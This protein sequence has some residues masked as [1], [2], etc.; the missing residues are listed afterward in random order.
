MRTFIAM[1]ATAADTPGNQ[2]SKCAVDNLNA[3]AKAGALTERPNDFEGERQLVRYVFALNIITGKLADH[4]S[5]IDQNVVIWLQRVT[6]EST[7]SFGRRLPQ[8]KK[9]DNLYVWSGAAAAAYLLLVRD[10]AIDR[11]QRNVWRE[12]IDAIEPDGRIAL[13]LARKEHALNYHTYYLSALLWLRELRRALGMEPTEQDA[14]AISRLENRIR[15]VFCSNDRMIEG[16]PMRQNPPNR[17]SS[18]ALPILEPPFFE[19][20]KRCGLNVDGTPPVFLGG[21]VELTKNYIS[22][23]RQR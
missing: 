5:G 17:L 20:M 8:R 21:S 22:A 4:H 15:A 18:E 16:Q 6:T 2:I 11:H 19:E 12:A 9:A 13:E 1:L 14:A 3:W 23:R 10:S 7:E